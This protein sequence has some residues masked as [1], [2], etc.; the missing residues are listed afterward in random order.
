V[1]AVV[2]N[3]IMMSTAPYKREIPL[4]LSLLRHREI[5]YY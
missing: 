1:W 4:N 3:T 5:L 2:E